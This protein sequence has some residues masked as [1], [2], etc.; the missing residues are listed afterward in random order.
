MAVF[1]RRRRPRTTRCRRCKA[2]IKVKTKGPVPKYCSQSCKQ[3][4]YLRRRFLSPVQLLERDLANFKVR[5][6]I[7]TT[8]LDILVE[9]GLV[10]KSRLPPPM[11]HKPKKP[12]RHLHLVKNDDDP[13][14]NNGPG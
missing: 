8:I 7:R 13:E 5:D 6:V 4:G 11:I 2:K 14:G 10:E 1:G 3:Q 12:N 9:V